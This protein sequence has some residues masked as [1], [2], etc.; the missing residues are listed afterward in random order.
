MPILTHVLA[1]RHC[2]TA[3]NV[4]RL[5]YRPSSLGAAS[6]P[7]LEGGP[8]FSSVEA[9]RARTAHDDVV[10]PTPLNSP[11]QSARVVGLPARRGPPPVLMVHGL[12]GRKPPAE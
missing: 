6:W 12:F 9:R 10:Y 1:V 11:P 4:A 3:G 7:R 2:K 5:R 8:L